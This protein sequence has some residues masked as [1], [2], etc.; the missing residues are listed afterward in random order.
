MGLLSAADRRV[1]RLMRGRCWNR[2]ACL[3]L[4]EYEA[5]KEIR[6]EKRDDGTAS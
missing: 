5:K 4:S 1:H 2:R 3:W 6:K